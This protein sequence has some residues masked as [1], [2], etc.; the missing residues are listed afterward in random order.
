MEGREG[1]EEVTGYVVHIDYKSENAEAFGDNFKSYNKD[2]YFALWGNSYMIFKD[3]KT[4]EETSKVTGDFME[5]YKD[6]DE[7]YV[8][9]NVHILRTDGIIKGDFAG[10]WTGW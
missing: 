2:G 10:S 7:L 6:T 9:G 3:E 4:Q 5:Y 8:S 1:N